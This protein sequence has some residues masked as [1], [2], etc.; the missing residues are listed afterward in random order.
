MKLFNTFI[1]SLFKPPNL[2]IIALLKPPLLQKFESMFSNQQDVKRD[3]LG[4]YVLIGNNFDDLIAQDLAKEPP[5]SQQE[6]E[7]AAKV[8]AEFR[9]GR[10]Y[11]KPVMKAQIYM[12]E[13]LPPPA[14]GT[15]QLPHP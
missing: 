12:R 15:L 14:P 2:K 4:E 8:F 1:Y 5:S 9:E 11:R 10:L 7:E 6:K 3:G 13:A